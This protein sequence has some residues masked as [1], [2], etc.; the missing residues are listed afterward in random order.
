MPRTIRFHLDE[1]CS[2]AIAAGLRR[3]GID[4]TTTPDAGLL[5]AAD[6]DHVAF[7]MARRRVVF[8]QDSDILRIH[9][10]GVP[11]PGIAFC[12]KDTRTTGEIIDTLHLMWEALEPE[13]MANR[14]EFLSATH[15]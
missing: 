12:R 9:A 1:N 2:N 7:A 3:Q 6:E 15:P 11:H 10:S 8:S 5:G 14:V 13:D 4:V